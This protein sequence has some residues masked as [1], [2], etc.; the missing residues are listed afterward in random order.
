MP[1]PVVC[2]ILLHQDRVLLA[3][4]P[5]GKHLALK[6][7]FPGGKVEDGESAEDALVRELREELGCDVRVIDELARSR[8]TYDRG[9]IE[10]IPF[11][12]ELTETSP[13][14]HPHEHAALVWSSA[15]ELL[16]HD[17]APADYPIVDAFQ[18]WRRLCSHGEP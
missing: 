11:V 6:W 10:M 14:P 17:L 15:E 13:P 16:K 1:L 8:H 5:Q 7:E 4:R 9:T 12:C 18:A 2:A 3:Q